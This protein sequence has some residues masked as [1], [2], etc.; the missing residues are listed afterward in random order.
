[1]LLDAYDQSTP[2][3]I[4]EDTWE[5][6]EVIEESFGVTHDYE[7]LLGKT[8]QELA[9]LL[10]QQ[11]TTCIGDTC[12]MTV[13]F[14]LLRKDLTSHLGVTKSAVR[15][16]TS[17]V[18]LLPWKKRRASWLLIQETLAVQLPRLAI[19]AWLLLAIPVLAIGA[20]LAFWFLVLRQLMLSLVISSLT[21]I[22]M[23]RASTSLARSFPRGCTTLADLLRLTLGLNY[24]KLSARY[25]GA[26]PN[27]IPSL[28][29]QVIAAQ[30]GTDLVEIRVGT[31]IPQGLKIH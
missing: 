5:F 11:S 14:Y 25:G 10:A 15:P 30:T 16:S 12:S 9:E 6:F 19:S 31:R 21:C 7:A 4:G 8:V 22:A 2:S 20:G 13:L 3:K 29:I 28:L 24:A 1:M 17:L 26:R 27:Q 23:V 18:A